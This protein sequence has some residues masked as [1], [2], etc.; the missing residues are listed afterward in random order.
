VKPI[1]A[2]L[3]RFRRP[4][5][6]PPAAA[7]ELESELMPIFALLDEIE[8]EAEVLRAEAEREA[9]RRADASLADAEGVLASWR[10]RAEAER[11]TIEREQHVLATTEARALEAEAVRSAEQV[12]IRGFERIP[13]LVGA[14]MRCLVQED[15]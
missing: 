9:A 5:G 10:R 4:A 15:T 13:Q 14:V 12:R 7:E 2:W 1:G 3:E 6:V 11:A 8:R